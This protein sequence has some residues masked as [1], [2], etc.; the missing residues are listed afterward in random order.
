MILQRFGLLLLSLVVL[1]AGCP[2]SSS[3]EE[4]FNKKKKNPRLQTYL[5]E[6]KLE[7]R[8]LLQ[9]IKGSQDTPKIRRVE[10][11]IRAMS[12]TPLSAAGKGFSGWDI[13]ADKLGE[14]DPVLV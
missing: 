6:A 7:I 12:H 9:E 8:K 1:I 4:S 11:Q 3:K 10:K 13:P 14:G 5:R 2:G